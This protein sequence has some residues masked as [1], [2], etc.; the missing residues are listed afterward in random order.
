VRFAGTAAPCLADY[1]EVSV[2]RRFVMERAQ[3]GLVGVARDAGLLVARERGID[4][5]ARRPPWSLAAA[6]F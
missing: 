5:G 6:L 1:P 4:A 2:E 3:R